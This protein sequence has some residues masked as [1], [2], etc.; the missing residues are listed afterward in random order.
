[1]VTFPFRSLVLSVFLAFIAFH[2]SFSQVV[3]KEVPD[4]EIR[5]SDS[6]FFDIT[7]TRSIIPL[8]GK[9][10]VRPAD[11]E[12]TAS[13]SVNVPS[14]F[15]GEGEMVFEK[16]F[17]LTRNQISRSTL[18]LIFFSVNYT[19]DIS[20]NN[21]II[22][23]HSGGEYPFK[24]LLP[25]D[26]LQSDKKNLLSVKLNYRLDS[27][28][29]IPQKQRFLFPQN[30]GGIIGDV[31]IHLTPDLHISKEKITKVFSSDY[32][33]VSLEIES[34]V[35]NNKLKEI[36]KAG[37]ESSE[38]KLFISLSNL[39][40]IIIKELPV[41]NFILERNK[42]IV[43]SQKIDIPVPVYWSPATPSSYILTEKL[44]RSDSLI[45]ITEKSIALYEL[46]SDK[47][48]LKLNGSE[49][50]LKGV[51]Y[52]PSNENFGKLLTYDQMENDILLI[53]E[54]GFNCVRFA[55]STVHPYFLNLCEKYGLLAFLEIPING[56]PSGIA[57]DKG[58][59]NRSKDFVLNYLS[60][61][62]D[63]SS[64]AAIGFG[65][66]YLPELEEH[67][68]L[69]SI[70]ANLTKEKS[71]RL[72]YASFYGKDLKEIDNLDLYGL[73]FIGDD[74]ANSDEKIKEL[75]NELGKGKVFF[76][77]CTYPVYLGSSDGYLNAFS[78]E[79]QAKYFEG[80]FDYV[81]QNNIPA[82]FINS[83]TDYEGDYSSF[84]CGY[85][86]TNLYRIGLLDENRNKNRISYKVV[87]SKLNNLEKV[88]IP[89]GNKKDDSPMVFIVSGL[90]LAIFMGV[91]VNS[92][93]KFRDDAS[94]ALLRPYNF[95]SDIRDQR[96]IS[97]YQTSIL[98]LII[99]AVTALIIS[100]I[101]FHLKDSLVFE[102]ILL[103]F[104]SPS[105]IKNINYLAWNPFMSL[106]WLT[107]LNIILFV[108]IALLIEIASFFAKTRV[109]IISVYFTF[110]WALL[111]VVLMIPVGIILYRVL[112]N[113]TI[114]L[115]IYVG[116]G[117]VILWILY[118]LMK[119]I[120]VLFD[121]KPSTVYLYSSLFILA[122]IG[123]VLFYF[124]LKHSTIQ[125]L[126][127]TFKQFNIF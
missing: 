108:I 26:I 18:E 54:A 63:Y 13:V 19:A 16:E 48:S 75:Q 120:H 53:K 20:L 74:V 60:Y 104:A 15:E 47:E 25:R 69:I 110:I 77:G 81:S 62:G 102:N 116:L 73:E 35:T 43:I 37:T 101:L 45:D 79:A 117:F 8:N 49:F 92:G 32:K 89:I 98:G 91:L 113:N 31:Y 46:K 115:Y 7:N 70:L 80:L 109:Y 23:R 12:K 106:L 34:L 40:G 111:P 29:S 10:N 52:C 11:D 125:Y 21:T 6:L 121:T 96:I 85:N 88:T 24:I 90:L 99:A 103:A 64:F 94:R 1:M 76:S 59:M 50:V 22:Y 118:R 33:N 57:D 82:F 41:Y 87:Y 55:K 93:R 17:D 66:T 84:I 72:T 119:G 27:K 39:N 124:E 51:V 114:N 126:L 36:P 122:V 83:F 112:L 65:G 30:Y 105:L 56:V 127:F 95:F 9:W 2:F 5:S 38:Y 100:N 4:Y 123:A 14:I 58:F 78:F 86:K 67:I 97:A 42:D 71:N 61:Y 44:F 3:F 107:G 68:S 28:N